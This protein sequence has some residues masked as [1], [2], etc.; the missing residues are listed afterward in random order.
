MQKE[1]EWPENNVANF[2]RHLQQLGIQVRADRG[3][4]LCDAPRGVLTPELQT[5]LREFKTDILNFL[6]QG[7][8]AATAVSLA[9]L[10]ILTT[11][12]VAARTA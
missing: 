10:V 5:R 12:A 3:R 2:L 9:A 7:E 11:A 8:P 1:S 6:A 4:L